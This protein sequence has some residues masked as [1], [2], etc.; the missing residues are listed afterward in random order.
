MVLPVV[1]PEEPAAAERTSRPEPRPEPLLPARRIATPEWTP[2]PVPPPLYVGKAVS[3]TSAGAAPRRRTAAAD[4]AWSDDP[5]AGAPA[6]DDAP[7]VVL[8]TRRAAGDW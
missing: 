6:R 4:T 1:K 5:Y 3:R 8:D 2:V 7:T